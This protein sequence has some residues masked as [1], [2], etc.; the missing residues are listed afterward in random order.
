MNRLVTVTTL[1]LL[2]VSFCALLAADKAV[3]EP[4]IRPDP[5]PTDLTTGRR[6]SN[7]EP[8]IRG[9]PRARDLSIGKTATGRSTLDVSSMTPEQSEKVRAIRQRAAEEIQT[10]RDRERAEIMAVLNEQQRGE[11][12]KME[13]DL[14]PDRPR[15][16]TTLPATT[17]AVE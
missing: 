11:Y 9:E 7:E 10:I 4:G 2:S 13:N 1:I 6:G 17:Q 15:R 16:V 8:A 12:A 3:D 14:K 5:R